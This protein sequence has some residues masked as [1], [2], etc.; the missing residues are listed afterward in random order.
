MDPRTGTN[1]ADLI[2]V[3]EHDRRRGPNVLS[4]LT[5]PHRY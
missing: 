3:P 1:S 4:T 5:A 2:W